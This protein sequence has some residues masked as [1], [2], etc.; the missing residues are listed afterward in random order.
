MV[1]SM[2]NKILILACIATAWIL[3]LGCASMDFNMD[4]NSMG[5]GSRDIG[6]DVSMIAIAWLLTW[7]TKDGH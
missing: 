6:M 1:V 7:M 3:V 4:S 2:A 5:S